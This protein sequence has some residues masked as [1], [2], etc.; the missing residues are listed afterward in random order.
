M[1]QL[2]QDL[3]G[4][5]H[6]ILIGAQTIPNLLPAI[7][8]RPRHAVMIST[9]DL[10]VG[11]GAAHPA[12]CLRDCLHQ[13]GITSER[14]DVETGF[15]VAEVRKAVREALQRHPDAIVNITG[16]T[17]L[18][19]L[20]AGQAAGDAE[21]PMLYLDTLHGA[22]HVFVGQRRAQFDLTASADL[23][24]TLAAH[25]WRARDYRRFSEEDAKEA[26]WLLETLP[27]WWA[28]RRRLKSD[29]TPQPFPVESKSMRRF[30][31]H[32]HESK[33]ARV[34][35]QQEFAALTFVDNRRA[36][37]YAGDGWIAAFVAGELHKAGAEEVVTDLKV[38]PRVAGD[39]PRLEE[40]V[41]VAAIK[42]GRAAF[43]S[44]KSSAGQF[45]HTQLH[46]WA[47]K[48]SKYGG[49]FAKSAVVAVYAHK[50]SVP[51]RP[52]PDEEETAEKFRA[53]ALAAHS[54]LFLYDDLRDHPEALAAL[55]R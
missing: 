33:A 9:L 43:I 15:D 19:M 5:P 24:L 7:Q 29:T 18:M 41:D 2:A 38:V 8:L 49:S 10:N 16:G 3:T 14:V 50:E 6:I 23:R 26:R 34:Q 20:G 1:D 17:K 53:Y 21:S 36:K 32:L 44:C 51:G 40:E 47:D 54:K 42:G 28:I 25:G 35:Y 48:A 52:H 37:F 30:F 27:E 31:N 13:L 39:A 4:R 46:E 12:D 45:N 55:L 11:D 22:I